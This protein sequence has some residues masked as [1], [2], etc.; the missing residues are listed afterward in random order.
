MNVSASEEGDLSRFL[1]QAP[2]VCL[3]EF[4]C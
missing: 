2:C 1:W 4:L 3:L